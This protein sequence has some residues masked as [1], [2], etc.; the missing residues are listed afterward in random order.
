MLDNRLCV[1]DN[2]HLN[3]LRLQIMELYE[4][5]GMYSLKG[6]ANSVL[7]ALFA[8]LLA[9]INPHYFIGNLYLLETSKSRT[10][11]S[12]ASEFDSALDISC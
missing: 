2:S 1:I 5:S 7:V 6:Y 4:C 12:L 9:T 10:Q 8:S 11:W 3:I